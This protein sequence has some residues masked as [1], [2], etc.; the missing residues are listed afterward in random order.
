MPGCRGAQGCT[1]T[2]IHAF[3]YVPA[4]LQAKN[5]RPRPVILNRNITLDSPSGRLL[6]QVNIVS[7]L[8][9]CHTL[10]QLNRVMAL[11]KLLARLGT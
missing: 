8:F 5:N 3:R 6:L 10:H 4:S 9:L 7:R 11:D 2:A 1:R